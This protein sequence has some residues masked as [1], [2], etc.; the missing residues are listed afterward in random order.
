MADIVKY[1]QF[2]K[3]VPRPVGDRRMGFHTPTPKL[4]RMQLNLRNMSLLEHGGWYYKC[5]FSGFDTTDQ[6]A[7]CRSKCTTSKYDLG[8]LHRL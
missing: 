3:N 6:S 7:N 4:H 2:I 5:V 1:R 8:W